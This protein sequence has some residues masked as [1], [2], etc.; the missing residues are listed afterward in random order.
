MR[1]HIAEAGGTGEVG[2]R[3]APE[4][5]GKHTHHHHRPMSGRTDNM[6]PRTGTSRADLCTAP[7]LDCPGEWTRCHGL[8]H[9]G[10]GR[11]RTATGPPGLEHPG[12]RRDKKTG[13][14]SP[15]WNIRGRKYMPATGPPGLEHPGGRN[16]GLEHPGKKRV[17]LDWGV[18][19]P[20]LHKK[21]E[22]AAARTSGRS[23]KENMNKSKER[24][25]V[26]G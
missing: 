4:K 17:A 10:P 26:D 3:R 11:S 22:A 12:G 5:K 15:D 21:E 14:R 23:V 1:E 2:Q 19:G 16:P 25:H 18:R 24:D 13:T 20:G 6:T 7:G 8:E 9:L